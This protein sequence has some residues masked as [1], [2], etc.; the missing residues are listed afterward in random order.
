MKTFELRLITLAILC[1]AAVGCG[2]DDAPTTPTPTVPSFAGTWAGTGQLQQ[3]TGNQA[4][5]VQANPNATSPVEF[6]LTQSGTAV[7]G[8]W[9][10]NGGEPRIPVTG[11]VATD[12]SLNLSG[13][14]TAVPV[15][16]DNSRLTVAGTSMSGTLTY[17]FTFPNP[18][19]GAVAVSIALQGV[20]RR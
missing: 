6:V 14:S 7:S 15:V 5:C 1:L 8:T 10:I 2:G 17:T 12:G 3:C 11:S 16:V 20:T 13:R 4:A 18:A 9:T 19:Q